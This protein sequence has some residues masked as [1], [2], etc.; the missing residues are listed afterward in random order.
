MR[1]AICLIGLGFTVVGAAF[2]PAG[3]PQ[4]RILRCQR[5]EPQLIDC[6]ETHKLAGL[7]TQT[8]ALA[9]LKGTRITSKTISNPDGDSTFYQVQMLGAQTTITQTTITV[10]AGSSEAATDLAAKLNHFIA[11]PTEASFK[12]QGG[13]RSWLHV[14]IG[15]LAVIGGLAV[16]TATLRSSKKPISG[17][18]SA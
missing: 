17:N 1:L 3:L 9:R 14:G 2:I 10:D 11:T 13:S 5:L 6:Q 18:P 12:V 15:L 4:T 7:T 8:T 16:V